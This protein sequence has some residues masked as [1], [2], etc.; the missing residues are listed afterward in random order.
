ML[1]GDGPE[2]RITQLSLSFHEAIV[3]HHAAKANGPRARDAMI[4]DPGRGGQREGR[5]AEA[6]ALFECS[7]RQSTDQ[8]AHC[9]FYLAVD[10]RPADNL[11]HF[12]ATCRCARIM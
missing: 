5:G 1:S 3:T 7:K 9:G 4:Y 8:T 2:V 11:V 10:R 12:G 6:A